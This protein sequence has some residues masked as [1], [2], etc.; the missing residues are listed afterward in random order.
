MKL[1]VLMAALFSCCIACTRNADDMEKEVFEK[2]TSHFSNNNN[3]ERNYCVFDFDN[4]TIVNDIEL[5]VLSYQINNLIFDIKPENMFETI[6]YCLPKTDTSVF[7][8]KRKIHLKSL[9]T[10]ISNDYKYLYHNYISQ[11]PENRNVKIFLS[12]EYSD[13]RAK[14]WALSLASTFFDY[15]TGCLWILSLLNGMPESMISK[16]AEDAYRSESLKKIAKRVLTSPDMGLTGKVSIEVYEGLEFSKK[17]SDLFNLLRNRG[18]D[19]FICSASHELIVKSVA[20]N[21]EFG[22]NIPEER[23]FGLKT[24]KTDNGLFFAKY[25]EKDILSFKQGKADIIKTYIAP[26]YGGKDPIITAGDSEGDFQMLTEFKNMKLGIVVNYK[27]KGILSS[28]HDISLRKSG[29]LNFDKT[30]Y[31][32]ID[33]H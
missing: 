9:A 21:P 13:F 4:T 20:C 2:L 19:I 11:K 23:V 5:A 28:L 12:D 22:I 25:D 1:T 18:F 26:L 24:I 3:Y 7:I 15:K 10:D 14:L 27:G 8:G 16:M 30:N 31:L 33:T 17:M 29:D 32:F 6:T